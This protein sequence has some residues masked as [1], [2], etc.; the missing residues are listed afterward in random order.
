MSTD[1]LDA[2]KFIFRESWEF[3]QT[4]IPGTDFSFGALLISVVLIDF[5]L[6]FLGWVFGSPTPEGESVNIPASAPIPKSHRISRR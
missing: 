6:K 2:I 3:F 5:G 4:D 1:L